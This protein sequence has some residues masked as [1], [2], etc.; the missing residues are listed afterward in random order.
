MDSEQDEIELSL[1]QKFAES[2]YFIIRMKNPITKG[3]LFLK[4]SSDSSGFTIGIVIFSIF[5]ILYLIWKKR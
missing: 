1:N 3:M 4:K 5:C 2:P